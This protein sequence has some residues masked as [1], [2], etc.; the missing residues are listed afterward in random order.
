[1]KFVSV[2]SVLLIGAVFGQDE[3]TPDNFD[4]VVDGSKN[5]FVMFYA[6]WCGHCKKFKPEYADVAQSFKDTE[7][8]VIASVDADAHR[9]LG[10]RYGVSGFPT[11]K[12]FEKGSTDATDF[13]GSRSADGVI[14]FI[15]EKAGTNV[16][17]FE[18]PLS[19]DFLYFY[20][21][22][23]CYCVF[24][25]AIMIIIIAILVFPNTSFTDVIFA[26]F[27]FWFGNAIYV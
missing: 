1:M 20:F 8:V 5:V 10:S 19:I 4:S 23:F 26:F 3:L 13:D 14:K 2:V 7:D 21:Y 18:A 16:K 11:L 17:V 24:S 12:F 15:N 27:C 25:F 22:F 9:D 6:P